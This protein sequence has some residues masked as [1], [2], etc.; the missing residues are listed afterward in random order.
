MPT[1]QELLFQISR[2][3]SLPFTFDH[4]VERV[5]RVLERIGGRTLII[6][7]PGSPSNVPDDIQ[8]F[9]ASFETRYRSFFLVALLDGG[10]TVGRA[11]L[12]FASDHFLGDMPRRVST[13]VGEQLGMLLGRERLA[14][15]RASLEGE[16][17]G[18]PGAR[19]ESSLLE[20]LRSRRIA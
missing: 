8:T 13:F 10:D 19:T 5:Q 18:L 7:L 11:V 2:I 20:S 3:V 12:C 17:R 9:L 6:E 15:T 4:A 16:I 1:E 14:E